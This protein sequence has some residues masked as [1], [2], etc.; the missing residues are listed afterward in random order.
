MNS[1]G[2]QDYS[3]HMARRYREEALAELKALSLSQAD[4]RL[5]AEVANFLVER[6]Y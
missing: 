1:L 5:F 4:Q 3:W 2:A 6:N